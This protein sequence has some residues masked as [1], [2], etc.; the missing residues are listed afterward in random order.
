MKARTLK[1]IAALTTGAALALSFPAVGSAAKGGVPNSDKPCP[2]K[3]K[4]A[5]KD[6]PNTK[7]KK[8]GFA[9]NGSSS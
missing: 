3:G 1:K 7:G 2:A 9:K 4:G 5:K 6:A 8:C